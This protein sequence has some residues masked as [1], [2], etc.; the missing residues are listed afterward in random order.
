MHGGSIRAGSSPTNAAQPSARPRLSHPHSSQ[1]SLPATSHIQSASAPV[2]KWRARWQVLALRRPAAEPA[3]LLEELA[4]KPGEAGRAVVPE[5][6]EDCL[7][8]LHR[9]WHLGRDLQV[10]RLL[11]P[12][13]GVVD[14]RVPE[15]PDEKPRGGCGDAETG[16]AHAATVAKGALERIVAP[17][18]RL[19]CV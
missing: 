17:G 12:R 10:D 4:A 6:D 18:Q 2:S 8:I 13:R 11:D 3:L 7:V 14:A 15:D 1:A 19:A 16:D 9:Q 5:C